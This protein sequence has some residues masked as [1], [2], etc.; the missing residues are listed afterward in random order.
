MG[1]ED[2]VGADGEN[3]KRPAETMS[4]APSRV[5]HGRAV[6]PEDSQEFRGGM[7]GLGLCG[8]WLCLVLPDPS[9]LLAQVARLA[10]G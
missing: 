9:A 7:G 10:A 4:W 3:A 2:S 8:Q 1:G 6:S 5:E